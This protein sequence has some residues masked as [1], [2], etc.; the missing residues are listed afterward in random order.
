MEKLRRGVRST[1]PLYAFRLHAR[2]HRNHVAVQLI[3]LRSVPFSPGIGFMAFGGTAT[4]LPGRTILVVDDEAHVRTASTRLL[5]RL[6]Q[7][8]RRQLQFVRALDRNF[9]YLSALARQEEAE[10]DGLKLIAGS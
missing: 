3:S 5:E 7:A 8:L 10:L 4:K 1:G 2:E 9:P 6:V